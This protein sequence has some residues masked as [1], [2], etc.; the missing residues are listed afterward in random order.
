MD[1]SE[2]FEI[3]NCQGV[4][5]AGVG[6]DWQVLLLRLPSNALVAP[7]GCPPA[8]AVQVRGPAH[9]AAAAARQPSPASILSIKCG[10]P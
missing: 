9:A 5:Y 8:D 4:E 3:V 2:F 10:S 1:C 7:A 6:V